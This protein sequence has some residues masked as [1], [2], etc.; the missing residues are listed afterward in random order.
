MKMSFIKILGPL[1]CITFS[2]FIGFGSGVS[3]LFLVIGFG[4]S[5]LAGVDIYNRD[6]FELGLI[7]SALGAAISGFFIGGYFSKKN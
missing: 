1:A 6:N 2:V 5:E 7:A 4:D 3:V